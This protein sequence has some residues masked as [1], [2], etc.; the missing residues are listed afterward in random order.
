MTPST[1][2]KGYGVQWRQQLEKTGWWHSF[3]LPDGSVNEGVIT[4]DGLKE[5]LAQ[6]PIPQ[7]LR[8]RRVL[9]IGTWDGWFAFEMERRGAEVVAVDCID[10]PRFREMH[11]IYGSRVDYRQMDMYE[12]SPETVGRFDYVLFLGVLY[13]LKHP[14][15]A[16]EKVCAV[17]KE[18]AVVESYVLR[19]NLDP[20]A[21]PVLEFY[22]SDEL[23]GQLDNWCGPNVACMLSMCRSAGFAGVE[24][25]KVHPYGACVTAYRKWPAG[26][27][28]GPAA[29]LFGVAH[30]MNGGINFDTRKDEYMIAQFESREQGLTRRD[31]QP[32]VG[33][34]GVY[35]LG[36]AYLPS[37]LWQVSFQL[38]PGLTP[39]W[40]EVRVGVRGGLP[41]QACRIA[42][43]LPLRPSELRIEG[44][45][46]GTTWTAD[47]VD[48]R[49]GR[50]LSI[51]CSG[52][53]E[54]ADRANV[55]VLAGGIACAVDAPLSSDAVR[56]LNATL[57]EVRPGRL[58]IRVRAGDCLSEPA[59]I[60]INHA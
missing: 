54:N 43:D 60:H 49:A 57:P 11:A 9:D 15:L 45:R 13:H 8:G 38:P 50:I 12:I 27:A 37:G 32:S 39:G 14:V 46:D 42:V 20:A 47:A 25:R 34:Y 59:Y 29:K 1:T 18:L 51:W 55:H 41:S 40:H 56:Q 58:E 2:E 48:L 31:I 36:V 10:N 35:P 33:G 3:E 21:T 22:E 19:D 53:P 28:S 52:L 4:I 23:E 24:L 17:A 5:R 6:F 26:D 7:D 44:L 30:R 16:L